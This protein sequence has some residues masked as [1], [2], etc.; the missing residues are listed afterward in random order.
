MY[1]Q[2][3]I[4]KRYTDLCARLGD[5]EYILTKLEQTRADLIAE[6]RSMDSVIP[7]LNI[8]EKAEQ[9]S[10]AQAAL[11]AKANEQPPKEN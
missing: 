6:L 7:K 8:E 11:S 1:T 10:V 2:K 9:E 3:T 4:N 5:T